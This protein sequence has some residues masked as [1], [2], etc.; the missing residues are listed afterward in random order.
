MSNKDLTP[1]SLSSADTIDGARA[2][3]LD[4]V[5]DNRPALTM[6][7]ALSV[8]PTNAFSVRL[9]RTACALGLALL[10]GCQPLAT[11]P[12]LQ[13]QTPAQWRNA[14]PGDAGRNAARAPDLDTW[15]R[16]FGDNQLDALVAQALADNLTIAQARSRLIAARALASAQRADFRPI[17]RAGTLAI[18]DPDATTSYF[19]VNLDA[20]WELGL[21]G[22]AQS[23]R[24]VTRAGMDAAAADL[25]GARVT[26]VAEVVRDYLALRS[27]QQQTVL[28]A[29]IADA[30]RAR[31][32]LIQRRR[33]LGLAA[34]ADLARA[35]ADL[36]QADAA[37]A[38]P[39]IRADASAQQLAVLCGRAEPAASL[40]APA[41]P[42]VLAAEAP[43]TLPADLLRTR[44]DIR[45]AESA[46][47]AAAGELGIARADLYPRLSLLGGITSS[48]TTAGG[49][50]GFGRAVSSFGPIIDMPLFDWGARR[51]RVAAKDAELSAAL[52][53]YRE[54]VL[55]AVAETETA[56][57]TW[58]AQRM[59]AGN[60]RTVIAA[61]ERDQRSVASGRRHGLADGMDQAVAAIALIQSRLDLLEAEQAQALAYVALYKALGG[62]PPFVDAPR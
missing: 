36:A 61:R 58:Q 20:Q 33:E 60:L 6:D 28:L 54:T 42:P 9:R 51:A 14:E 1:L 35:D 24:R 41:T 27:A 10:T 11:V 26:L 53:G 13:P 37:L 62:A 34:D 44:P 25:Q 7:Y 47:L 38:E 45:H 21:F 31:R 8:L 5:S 46:V 3:S 32:G 49:Q 57:A 4:D 40:L 16:A 23:T 2:V 55:E 43:V 39:R 22:R 56:L 19:Q 15:W 29:Q 30:S 59:R 50:F 48:T 17:V 12:V 52:D 18:P